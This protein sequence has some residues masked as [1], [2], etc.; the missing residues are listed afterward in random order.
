[1]ARVKKTLYEM[2][3]SIFV[4][5]LRSLMKE[6]KV[7]QADIAAHIGRSRQT[8]SEY[9]LGS[10]EPPFS[11]LVKIAD[12]FNTTTDYLVGRTNDPNVQCSAVDDIGLSDTAVKNLIDYKRME[13]SG[14]SHLTLI[15]SILSDSKIDDVMEKTMMYFAMIQ[16]KQIVK[17]FHQKAVANGNCDLLSLNELIFCL[18]SENDEDKAKVER[19]K[20]F[21]KPLM[22]ATFSSKFNFLVKSALL[23][24]LDFPEPQE[25]RLDQIYA[26]DALTLLKEL[27]ERIV[28]KFEEDQ[29]AELKNMGELD[30]IVDFDE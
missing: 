27:H 18:E 5:R 8:V 21:Y 6:R 16:A 11:V 13:D 20:Q 14:Y 2:E 10:S 29:W 17:Y 4:G 22:D 12:F 19:S 24:L 1:M 15:N 26:L 7:T 9:V 25:S 28:A 3:T 30:D 23:R